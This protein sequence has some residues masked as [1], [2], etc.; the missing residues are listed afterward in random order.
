MIENFFNVITLTT[1]L[2]IATFLVAIV[3]FRKSKFYL[4]VT[5]II[6][7]NLF[8]EILGLTAVITQKFTV[9]PFYNLNFLLQPAL[10]LV[11]LGSV[12]ENQGKSYTLAAIFFVFGIVNLLFLE[13]SDLNDKTFVL[14]SFFYIA[15]Y[16]WNHFQHLKQENLNYFK[17]NDFLIVSTPLAFF[18]GISILLS[19]GDS[20][21][22]SVKLFN[23]TLYT[24]IQFLSNF[25]FYSLFIIYLIK[26]R[27]EKTP[28]HD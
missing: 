13:K 12:F 11:L 16:I 6:I 24:I 19:F 27:N 9:I 22:R 1:I 20:G 3:L 18:F 21:L 17:S 7:I 4:L 8:S 14:G 23:R 28:A 5:A 10:W 2:T 26:S 15:F 25:I